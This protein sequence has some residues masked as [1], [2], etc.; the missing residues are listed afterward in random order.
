MPIWAPRRTETPQQ[1]EESGLPNLFGSVLHEAEYPFDVEWT[2]RPAVIRLRRLVEAVRADAASG[3]GAGEIGWRFHLTLARLIA[4]VCGQIAGATGLRTVALT[5]GCF[6]NR[7]LLGLA[8]PRLEAAGF[9][10][11]LHGQVPCNDGGV[12]LG[13]AALA[14]FAAAHDPLSPLGERA[15]PRGSV[16]V[17]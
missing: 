1:A 16:G 12:S 8:V 5:G 4:D 17:G 13:Q 7:L 9:R 11:L 14:H 15:C 10:V 2:S 6:Q 3:A